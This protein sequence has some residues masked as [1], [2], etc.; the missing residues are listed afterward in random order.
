M[1][2]HA[3][4]TSAGGLTLKRHKNSLPL[5][6]IQLPQDSQNGHFLLNLSRFGKKVVHGKEVQL[7]GTSKLNFSNKEYTET[8]GLQKLR[9]IHSQSAPNFWVVINLF[10]VRT[11]NET[12]EFIGVCTN[13]FLHTNSIRTAACV[14]ELWI[15]MWHWEWNL[16]GGQ[17]RSPYRWTN[18]IPISVDKPDPHIG[19]QTRSPYR[20]TNQIPISVDKP[21]THIGWQTGP[22]SAEERLAITMHYLALAKNPFT[23]VRQLC[24]ICYIYWEEKIS[25]LKGGRFPG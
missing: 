22:L 1:A 7:L 17:T 25:T 5:N 20:W 18:Q 8:V 9:A 11:L 6:L 13:K 24:K 12:V 19:G 10:V 16:I 15:G 2:Y 21:D 23:K 4:C 14:Y 3:T